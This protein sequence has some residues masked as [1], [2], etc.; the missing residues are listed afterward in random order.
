MAGAETSKRP[1]LAL[2]VATACGIG[3]VPFAPG[4]FGSA[5]GLLLWVVLPSSLAA[6]AT[7]IIALLTLGVWCSHLVE[8]WLHTTDPGPIVID[9]VVGM[10]VTLFGV[11]VGW[12]AAVMGFL[13]F[14]VFDII[15]PYPAGKL[16]HLP[17][18]VGVM[19]D[20]LMAAI[21]ASLTLRLTMHW[22]I[23]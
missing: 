20:D 22:V 15:K 9:E 18:G 19:A 1:L 23:G 8:R 17:G 11:A 2:A 7:A 3:Y 10:L 6:Q 5:A 16:E 4:T 21:Y 12:P 14:R 13:L